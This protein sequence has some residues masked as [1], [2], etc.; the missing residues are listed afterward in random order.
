MLENIKMASIIAA[1]SHEELRDDLEDYT[2]LLLKNSL[3]C[4]SLY[5]TL[6]LDTLVAIAKLFWIYGTKL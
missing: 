3:T 1:K 5:L 2:P 4:A 6:N